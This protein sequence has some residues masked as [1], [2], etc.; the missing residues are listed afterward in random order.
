MYI[1]YSESAG[2]SVIEP[3]PPAGAILVSAYNVLPFLSVLCSQPS[4]FTSSLLNCVRSLRNFFSGRRL[5]VSLSSFTV[6]PAVSYRPAR[7]RCVSASSAVAGGGAGSCAAADCG[8][9]RLSR[10]KCITSLYVSICAVYSS[11]PGMWSAPT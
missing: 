3:S 10:S 8:L 1:P 11:M 2:K 9:S 4:A 7:R 5:P 6:A